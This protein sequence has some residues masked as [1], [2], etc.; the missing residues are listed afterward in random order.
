[1]R[2]TK[3]PQRD[4]ENLQKTNHAIVGQELK[5]TPSPMG[6]MIISARCC[7]CEFLRQFSN[8]CS[9]L[10]GGS[11]ASRCRLAFLDSPGQVLWKSRSRG[12]VSRDA[13]NTCLREPRRL[14]RAGCLHFRCL[15]LS[16]MNLTLRKIRGNASVLF[17][18]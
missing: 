1:M 6:Q 4:K 2:E 7:D 5:T 13:Q 11:K 10:Q 9:P 17:C 8:S 18:I 15:M 3:R 12:W 14:G 16:E